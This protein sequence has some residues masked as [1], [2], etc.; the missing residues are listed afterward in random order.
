MKNKL[1][2]MYRKLVNFFTGFK[3]VLMKERAVYSVLAA[4]IICCVLASLTDSLKIPAVTFLVHAGRAVSVIMALSYVAQKWLNFNQMLFGSFTG[5]LRVC[6]SSSKEK[7]IKKM[8]FVLKIIFGLIKPMPAPIFF[9]AYCFSHQKRIGVIEIDVIFAILGTVIWT[10]INRRNLVSKYN[11]S[12]EYE[13]DSAWTEI[14]AEDDEAWIRAN[15]L[16]GRLAIPA[17]LIIINAVIVGIIYK[18]II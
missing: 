2:A 1:T 10:F 7:S 16:I 11:A 14:F 5:M 18:F 12:L 8:R 15:I 6:T 9:I 17:L 13:A 3:T 4:A